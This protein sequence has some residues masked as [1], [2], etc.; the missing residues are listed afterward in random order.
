MFNITALPSPNVV[1]TITGI[2]QLG[3]EYTL[4]CTVNV[5]DRLIVQP[6]IQ[7]SKIA[8][9]TSLVEESANDISVIPIYNGNVVILTFNTLKISDGGQYTC[10]AVLM[11]TEINVIVDGSSDEVIQ[12]QSKILSI[13]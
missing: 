3:M 2:P 6:D 8:V 9:N 10:N 7:W 1:L 11:I 13:F 12:F 5:I 4:N